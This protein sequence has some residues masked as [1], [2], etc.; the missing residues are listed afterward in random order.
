MFLL[1]K[2]TTININE[3][4]TSFLTTCLLCVKELC[5]LKDKNLLLE[6]VSTVRNTYIPVDAG[7][8]FEGQINTVDFLVQLLAIGIFQ[9]DQTIP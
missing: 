1:V 8:V 9:K 7:I 5:G 4:V 3:P 6:R 2:G